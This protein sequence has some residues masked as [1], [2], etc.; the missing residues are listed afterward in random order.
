MASGNENAENSS[1]MVKRRPRSIK[2][3][4]IRNDGVRGSNPL[5]GTTFPTIVS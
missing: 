1:L 4:I 5:S 3:S 2:I